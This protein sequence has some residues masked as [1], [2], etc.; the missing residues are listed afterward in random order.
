MQGR[1]ICLWPRQSGCQESQRKWMRKPPSFVYVLSSWMVEKKKNITCFRNP[2]SWQVEKS[3]YLFGFSQK[4]SW[5]HITQI[6]DT[7]S[8]STSWKGKVASSTEAPVTLGWW[9]L[10]VLRRKT[11]TFLFQTGTSRDH[12]ASSTSQIN[13]VL[14]LGGFCSLVFLEVCGKMSILVSFFKRGR[15]S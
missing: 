7:F 8:P 11:N 14:V 4:N 12:I 15:S 13:L 3:P 2:V 5:H 10:W 1:R 9:K 6:A